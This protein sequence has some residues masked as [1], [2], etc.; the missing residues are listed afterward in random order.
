MSQQLFDLKSATIRK[1]VQ[2]NIGERYIAESE[3]T[4][5]KPFDKAR[6][7]PEMFTYPS[8]KI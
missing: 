5:L 7:A 1:R 6:L 4:F 2:H 3:S 8:P